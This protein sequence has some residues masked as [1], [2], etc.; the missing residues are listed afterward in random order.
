MKIEV[1]ALKVYPFTLTLLHLKQAKL[2][3]VLAVLR[4]IGLNKYSTYLQSSNMCYHIGQERVTGNIKWYTKTLRKE[5]ESNIQRLLNGSF[6][7]VS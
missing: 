1:L 4:A 3:R 5:K 2:H 7:N 6:H